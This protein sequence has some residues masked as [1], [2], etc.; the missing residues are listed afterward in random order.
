MIWFKAMLASLCASALLSASGVTAIAS[1]IS[2]MSIRKE[3]TDGRDYE[4]RPPNNSRTK[5][6]TKAQP[7]PDISM[8]QGAF[9]T[10]DDV[11]P[12][13]DLSGSHEDDLHP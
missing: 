10:P 7:Q 8:D 4:K 3:K 5:A 6:A 1:E 9:W 13:Y 11:G 2:S 12:A